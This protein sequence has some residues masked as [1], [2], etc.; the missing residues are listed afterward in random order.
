MVANTAESLLKDT[1][2][3][4][5]HRKYLSTKDT[6]EAPKMVYSMVAIHFSSP[7]VDNLY[8]V[9]K[10]AVPMCP[11]G[12]DFTVEQIESKLCMCTPVSVVG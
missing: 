2:N 1:L 12:R 11:L 3:K 8:T 5:H 4:V 9:D 7:R 10:L 6:L